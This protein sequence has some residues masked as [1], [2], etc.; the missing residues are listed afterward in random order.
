MARGR[1]WAA[2]WWKHR[3][4]IWERC[5]QL[6]FGALHQH[7]V[8]LALQFYDEGNENKE[9]YQKKRASIQPDAAYR[10]PSLVVLSRA[11]W[12]YWSSR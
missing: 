7:D 12:S 11:S 9:E 8:T 1:I 2:W 6:P 10:P 5:K 4:A 3:L